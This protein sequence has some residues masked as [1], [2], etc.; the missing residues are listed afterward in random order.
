MR[1]RLIEL[2]PLAVAAGLLV[3]AS[4]SVAAQDGVL[5]V[6]QLIRLPAEAD[7]K[8]VQVRGVL[9]DAGGVSADFT[10]R[11]ADENTTVDIETM[12]PKLRRYVFAN[13]GGSVIAPECEFV[14][15]GEVEHIPASDGGAAYNQLRDARPIRPPRGA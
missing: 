2:L 4:S 8:R 15:D 10:D 9:Y 13:C 6:A 14:L 1:M 7:G 5:S 12:E 11:S 3:A